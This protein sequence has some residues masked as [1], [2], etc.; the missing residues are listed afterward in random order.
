M[1]WSLY[2]KLNT[3]FVNRDAVHGLDKVLSSA[4]DAH[5]AVD[6]SGMRFVPR[7]ASLLLNYFLNG[8]ELVGASE[9]MQ[10]FLDENKR[11]HDIQV[12]PDWPM[13]QMPESNDKV[14]DAIAALEKGKDYVADGTLATCRPY[15]AFLA[16]AII[17]KPKAKIYMDT[18]AA[19]LMMFLSPLLSGKLNPNNEYYC[20]RDHAVIVKKIIDDEYVDMDHY[21]KV[22]KN[23]FFTRFYPVTTEI[24]NTKIDKKAWESELTVLISIVAE[25]YRKTKRT[26]LYE[27]L[28]EGD[29]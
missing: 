18:I 27:Y 21:G 6:I 2:E 13:I 10:S 11:R 12:N 29:T 15:L 23:S 7:T 1:A 3:H 24:G 25:Y 20:V 22:D 5:E 8:V 26:T 14:A 19:D 4:R 9:K 17:Y 16:L 28:Q